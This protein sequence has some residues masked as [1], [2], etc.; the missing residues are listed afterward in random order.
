MKLLLFL[1]GCLLLTEQAPAHNR[2]RPQRWRG[3]AGPAYL[4]GKLA[5]RPSQHKLDSLARAASL[6]TSPATLWKK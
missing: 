4:A 3:F 5:R 1:L 6:R 2:P